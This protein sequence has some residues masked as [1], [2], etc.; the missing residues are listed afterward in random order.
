M[1]RPAYFSV[2]TEQPCAVNKLTKACDELTRPFAVACARPQA[3]PKMPKAQ[4][5]PPADRIPGLRTIYNLYTPQTV[6]EPSASKCEARYVPYCQRDAAQSV[7]TRSTEAG[8]ATPPQAIPTSRTRTAPSLAAASNSCMCITA[9]NSPLVGVGIV[10]HV[11]RRHEQ[12]GRPR[13][14]KCV[15]GRLHT[16]PSHLTAANSHNRTGE[17]AKIPVLQYDTVRSAGHCWSTTFAT[18]PPSQLALITHAPC[19][20]HRPGTASTD[21]PTYSM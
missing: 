8:A 12:D 4:T 5:R 19:K 18:V 6:Y 20:S 17:P 13:G 9:R 11:L 14:G 3:T 2:T 10:E 15:W 1:T 21:P 16:Q 7:G